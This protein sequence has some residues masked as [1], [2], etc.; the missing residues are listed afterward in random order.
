M[1]GTTLTC[2]PCKGLGVV[3]DTREEIK[4]AREE[5]I[6]AREEIERETGRRNEHLPTELSKTQQTYRSA[7]E[8]RTS[9]KMQAAI[10]S[11]C[12]DCALGDSEQC[13]FIKCP[14]A[15]FSPVAAEIDH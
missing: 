15:P 8:G 3:P 14:L 4:Q 5:I 2:Y 9:K 11:F 1:R 6:K 13:W 10:A 7:A 12:G